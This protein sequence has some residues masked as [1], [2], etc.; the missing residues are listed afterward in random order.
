MLILD[1]STLILIARIEILDLFL[2]SASREVA[3]PE[4]LQREC[5]GVQKTLD[6]LRIQK[7]LDKSRIKVVAVK[8][9][10]LVGKLGHDFSSGRGEAEAIALA[11]VKQAKLLAIDDKNGINACKLLEIAFVTAAGILVR[12]REKR[13]LNQEEALA[14]LGLLERYG[15]YKGSILEDVKA[16]LEERK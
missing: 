13:L 10:K 14:R 12:C 4:E 11:V 3:V 15:R 16:R 2:R 5:C 1:S 8:D 6:A 7:A 9:T